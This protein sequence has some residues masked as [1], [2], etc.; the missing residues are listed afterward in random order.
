MSKLNDFLPEQTDEK[1]ISVQIKVPESIYEILKR[2]L[3]SKNRTMQEVGLAGLELFIDEV[4]H[5]AK[6]SKR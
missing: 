3:K 2:T 5:E 1:M 4:K 6:S